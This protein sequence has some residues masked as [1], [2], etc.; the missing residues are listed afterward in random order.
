[1]QKQ[2]AD[3]GQRTSNPGICRGSS[4]NTSRGPQQHYKT[5]PRITEIESGIAGDKIVNPP[6]G[7]YVSNEYVNKKY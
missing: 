3:G 7:P 2:G 6:V 1:M 5:L 4:T